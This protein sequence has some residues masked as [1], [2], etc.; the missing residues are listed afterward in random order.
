MAAWRGGETGGGGLR[1]SPQAPKGDSSG[2]IRLSHVR[3]Q[4]KGLQVAGPPDRGAGAQA[5]PS[6]SLRWKVTSRR[7]HTFHRLTLPLQANQITLVASVTSVHCAQLARAFSYLLAQTSR[8]KTQSCLL[9]SPVQRAGGT[10]LGPR[11][12]LQDDAIRLVEI[13]CTPTGAGAFLCC[14]P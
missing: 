8:R 1:A 7:W 9:D 10:V 4:Y 5:L 11:S 6:A 14:W 13:R 12:H 2:F 3:A